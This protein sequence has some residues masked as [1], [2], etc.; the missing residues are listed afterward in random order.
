MKL[1]R[2]KG[3]PKIVWICLFS[4]LIFPKTVMG[5]EKGYFENP[6]EIYE[7]FRDRIYNESC[8]VEY[9]F[10]REGEPI[11]SDFRGSKQSGKAAKYSGVM[12]VSKTESYLQVIYETK[13]GYGIGWMDRSRY[14]E[15]SR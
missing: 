7:R 11:Y 1:Q 8:T 15:I 2:Q 13:T 5:A 3:M 10:L 9:G 6:E 14:R 4:I 12:V